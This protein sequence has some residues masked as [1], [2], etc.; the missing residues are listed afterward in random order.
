MKSAILEEAG[1]IKGFSRLFVTLLA[2]RQ[3]GRA[4]LGFTA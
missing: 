4:F 2:Q 1:D 3:P